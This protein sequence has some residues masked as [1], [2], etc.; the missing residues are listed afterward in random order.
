[1]CGQGNN[2]FQFESRSVYRAILMNLAI[3]Q[4]CDLRVI[5][6]KGRF[7]FLSQPQ[8][9]QSNAKVL[10]SGIILLFEPG[11]FPEM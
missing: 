3:S 6:V 7:T 9:A 1:M 5:V 4:L 8:S 11:S 10:M 2:A